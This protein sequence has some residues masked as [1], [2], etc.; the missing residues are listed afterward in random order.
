MKYSWEFDKFDSEIFGFKVAKIRSLEAG[1]IKDLIKDLGK[2][3]VKYA[4]FR[5]ES[6]NFKIIHTLEKS[7]FILVDGLIRLSFKTSVMKGEKI[8]NEIRKATDN[9]LGELKELTSRLFSTGRVMNDSFIP[10]N[11]ARQFYV[12]WIENSIL[13]KAAESVLVWEEG[14]KILGYITL[15]KSG[16]I[17]LLGV[18]EKAR[19]KGTGKKLINAALLEFKEWGVENIILETQIDNISALRLYQSCGFKIVNSFLTLRW[20]EDD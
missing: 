9:D 16:Q 20:A 6:N 8:S 10:K 19:G 5:L 15:M 18:S 13:G 1:S 12:R 2:N 3:K 4:T 17:P 7:G 14:R 11:K